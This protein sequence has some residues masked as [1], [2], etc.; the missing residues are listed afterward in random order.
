MSILKPL[1]TG[2]GHLKAGLQGFAGSGKTYTATV[3]AIGLRKFMDLKGPIAFL[4]TE[5]GSQYVA[6]KVLKETGAELIGV[7]SHA[8]SDLMATVHDAEKEG[9]SV[10]LVDSVSHIWEEL[11]NS[12]LQR[13]NENLKRRNR[14]ARYSLEFQDYGPLKLKWAEWTSAFLNSKLH[15]IFCGRA[16]FSYD[17][18]TNEDT[19]KKELI[20]TG[21][22]MKVENEFGYEPSLLIEME[23]VT[24]PRGKKAATVH[25]ATILKDRFDQINGGEF[26]NPTFETFLPHISQLKPGAH[27]PIDT[28]IK[29]EPLIDEEGHDDRKRRTILLE[30]IQAEIVEMHPSQ[31]ASDKAA[32]NKL[33]FDV[34]N[35]KSWTAVEG[36]SAEGLRN[37]LTDIRRR[38]GDLPSPPPELDPEIMAAFAPGQAQ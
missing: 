29:T 16:G 13:V 25:R 22:K 20:K 23:R 3:M 31:S 36:M 10:L 6:A 15:I 30:E 8:F 24:A 21:T 27:A 1:G 33:V 14:P 35:T 26:D 17:H 34:F 2:Q 11:K 37:G 9:V 12:H 38:K 4:D 19:G 32:K 7:R 28:S 5:G 18:E